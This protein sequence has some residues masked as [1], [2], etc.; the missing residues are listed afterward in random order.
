[1]ATTSGTYSVRVVGGGLCQSV[2]SNAITVTV[3][4]IPTAPTITASGNTILC[5][6]DSVTLSLPTGGTYLWSTGATG[7]SLVV[8]TAG[9]YFAQ[10][11]SGT[12]TSTVSR[13]IVV[14]VNP[15]PALP[16]IT[17]LVDTL[18]ITPQANTVVQWYL[19]GSP[20]AGATA[21]SYTVTQP[22]NYSARVTSLVG[23]SITSATFSVITDLAAKE[24]TKFLVYPNPTDGDLTISLSGLTATRI[25]LSILD[26]QG[27]TYR[28]ETFEGVKHTLSVADL[29]QG[30]WILQISLPDGTTHRTRFVKQ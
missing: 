21:T 8:K 14:T 29:A 12:C 24:A 25:R 20:I 2:P 17:R 5:Q 10:E 3:T 16:V 28:T 30:A 7:T 26:L 23:C 22:G 15:L 18:S 13:P 4:P 19:G 6:G 11:I 1:V 9:S 27:R